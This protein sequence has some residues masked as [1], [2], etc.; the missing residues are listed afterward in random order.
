MT[1]YIVDYNKLLPG[2]I[3]LSAERA[4]P[5][6]A[7]RAATAARYSHAAV[8]VGGSLIQAT[9]DGV[10][11]ANPQR[12][13]FAQSADAAVYRSRTP[14][15]ERQAALICNYARSCVGSLYALSELALLTL[16][17]FKKIGMPATKRQF[18]SRLVA[19]AYA[20]AGYELNERISP[21][22]C[23]PRMIS[24]SRKLQAVP[25]MIRLANLEELDIAASPDGIRMNQE[26]LF[27]WVNGIRSIVEADP[28]LRDKFDI[29]SD[30][31]A[32]KLLLAH[33]EL[34]GQATKLLRESGYLS[35][36]N[37]DAT[38]ER[39]SYRYDKSAMDEALREKDPVV[40]LHS[41]LDKEP[42]MFDRFDSMRMSMSMYYR[43][44]G[45]EF[46]RELVMLYRNLLHVVGVRLDVIAYGFDRAGDAAV[47]ESVRQLLALTERAITE[48]DELCA[49]PAAN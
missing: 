8:W 13:H 26:Q 17:R 45:L 4:L 37:H 39:N 27:K 44:T 43:D 18:C 19:M 41:E 32:Y 21:E 36:Y 47:A 33:P 15:T 34:D 24:L 25:G 20:Y 40:L 12:V 1:A 28:S 35:F 14:L 49:A 10:F 38:V 9:L 30:S 22:F 29:Q 3:V 23:T 2:D 7:I 5:S 42:R 16:G 48:A 31:D 46:F 11:S 6:K